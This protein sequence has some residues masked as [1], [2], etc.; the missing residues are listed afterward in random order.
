MPKGF[1]H[2]NQNDTLPVTGMVWFVELDDGW[3][4]IENSVAEKIEKAIAAN[5]NPVEHL[6]YWVGMKGGEKTTRYTYDWQTMVQ[7]NHTS[8]QQ[9]TIVRWR[10]DQAA[11]SA[12]G[13][14]PGAAMP[15]VRDPWAQNAS[16]TGPA[17]NA[18]TAPNA[19]TAAPSNAEKA[20]N[21]PAPN[22]TT[23]PNAAT[24]APSP[25]EEFVTALAA[26][27]SAAT[28]DAV[29]VARQ[30][31]EAE[32]AAAMAA[33]A[34]NT[35]SEAGRYKSSEAALTS[36]ATAEEASAGETS[37]RSAAGAAP[38]SAAAGAAP[39]SPGEVA[40]SAAGGALS[41]RE[42]FQARRVASRNALGNQPPAIAQPQTAPTSAGEAATSTEEANPSAAGAAPS[43][44]EIDLADLP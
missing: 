44:R 28:M 34:E 20:P 16:P 43:L 9:R 25:M 31:H 10:I 41:G 8:N 39:T 42:G 33:V 36:A 17:P 35:D 24:A 14:A 5:Q 7:Q 30:Q 13:A 29:D 37:P 26:V 6:H 18:T 1:Q 19:A 2:A 22:A 38:K 27:D 4:K 21:A 15:N 12:A 23:A 32:E 11:P 3:I 40:P